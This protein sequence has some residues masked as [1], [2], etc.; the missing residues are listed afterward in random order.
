MNIPV[1][2]SGLTIVIRSDELD[3]NTLVRYQQDI[4]KL[5]D[6][7]VFDIRGGKAILNFDGDGNLREIEFS[8]KEKV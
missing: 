2:I 1:I 7:G 8:Y 3:I 4:S 5:I 6:K